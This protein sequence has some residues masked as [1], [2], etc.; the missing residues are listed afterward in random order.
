M[1]HWR[2]G[3]VAGCIVLLLSLGMAPAQGRERVASSH[4]LHGGSEVISWVDMAVAGIR[5]ALANEQR[6][7]DAG[8]D[9]ERFR[10]DAELVLAQLAEPTTAHALETQI[11]AAYGQRGFPPDVLGKV[12]K[13]VGAGL[14]VL[15]AGIAMTVGVVACGV[16]VVCA[17]AAIVIGVGAM[18][19]ISL[20][21]A[22]DIIIESAQ[23]GEDAVN[24]AFQTVTDPICTA[25]RRATGQ[26]GEGCAPAP[27][28]IAA[29]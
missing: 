2:A 9:F 10:A 4:N 7:T 29:G 26:P 24:F 27:S 18:V 28:P 1:K 13:A 8:Y 21:A 6:L 12:F 25:V 17:A 11:Q 14:G 20:D 15:S 16:S 5:H 3:F 23:D 22:G 19:G